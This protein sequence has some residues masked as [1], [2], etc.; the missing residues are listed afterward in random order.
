MKTRTKIFIDRLVGLPLAWALNFCA[1]VLGRVLR[2]NHDVTPGSVRTI[3][4]SKYLGMGSILQATPLIRSIRAAFP[5][6]TIIF[7]TTRGCRRLVERLE[8]VDAVMTID[9]GGLF[10]LVRTTLRVIAQLIGKRVDLFFDL[11]LYSAYA[12]VVSLLSLSRNR[13]GFY[14][15]SAQHKRGNYTHLM[16][17]NTRSPIRNIYLQL[18]RLVGCRPVEPDR[19]GRIRIDPADRAEVAAKLPSGVGAGGYLVVNP[20]ASDL[21][22]ERRWPVERFAALIDRLLVGHDLPVILIG[23][24]LERPYVAALADLTDRDGTSRGRVLNLAGSLS[25]G[26]LFALLEGARCVVT[27]D[28]GPMHMAWALGAPT[29]GLFGPVDPGHYG[30]AATDF[31]ILYKPVYCSPCVHEVDEPPCM[32]D[33]VCM[34]RIG[35]GEVLD[36]VARVLSAPAPAPAPAPATRAPTPSTD[37]LYY[38][39]QDDRPLG[40]V[41]RLGVKHKDVLADV[42]PSA[43][44]A[45]GP[46]VAS[47]A[48]VGR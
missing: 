19:L 27:N 14:R 25:L 44:R 28:T 20:N 29:V 13:I 2:R 37:P 47:P 9:D 31:Q 22:I 21:M 46:A 7:L 45:D 41:V 23:A 24:P 43:A 18:G 16:Y 4:V 36:A 5:D 6:A 32:G 26:G 48:E 33:N 3:V 30:R 42:G 39:D 15:E 12:S 35:V 11:E 1:R 34:Q 40:R 10:G 38:T 8:H 17:F